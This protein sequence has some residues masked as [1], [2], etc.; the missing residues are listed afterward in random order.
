KRRFLSTQCLSLFSF[1][2][3]SMQH[4][5]RRI[6]YL[7]VKRTLPRVRG[8]YLQRCYIT[9]AQT[10]FKFWS[11]TSP[12]AEAIPSFEEDVERQP[13]PSRLQRFSSLR[14][15]LAWRPTSPQL[16]R[17]AETLMLSS[18]LKFF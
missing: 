12:T 2:P 3:P 4:F 16:Q 5:R 18:T 15:S 8:H 13:P 6:C 9:S 14:H 7:A 10:R 1:L 11:Q 17:E